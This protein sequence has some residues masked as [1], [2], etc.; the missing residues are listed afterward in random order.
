MLI[1]ID[2]DKRRQIL[3]FKPQTFWRDGDQERLAPCEILAMLRF[4]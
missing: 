4:K 1:R 2:P 3:V